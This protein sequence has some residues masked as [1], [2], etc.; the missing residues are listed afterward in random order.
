[1]ERRSRLSLA[2]SRVTCL[3]TITPAARD[4]PKA[5]LPAPHRKRRDQI[6]SR[7]I[8]MVPTAIPPDAKRS[9]WRRGLLRGMRRDARDG[10]GGRLPLGAPPDRAPRHTQSERQRNHVVAT[11]LRRSPAR[12]K[13]LL[14]R[15]K[16]SRGRFANDGADR[17]FDR[18]ANEAEGSNQG[19]GFRSASIVGEQRGKEKAV[20]LESAWET[21]RGGAEQCHKLH[22]RPA[23]ERAH[24]PRAGA[25]ILSVPTEL[26]R[27]V[28]VLSS[29][30]YLGNSARLEQNQRHDDFK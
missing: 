27:G 14:R 2:I 25:Q 21:Q 15:G 18:R 16:E 13:R 10:D 28:Q 19:P 17:Q 23:Q 26:L 6:I 3:V 1:M 24:E 11:A 7:Y 12:R 20:R 22:G 5:G 4:E 8:H 9:R 29:E 30:R